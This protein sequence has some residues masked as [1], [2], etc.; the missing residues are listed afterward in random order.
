[1]VWFFSSSYATRGKECSRKGTQ[2]IADAGANVSPPV[3]TQL[4]QLSALY[5]RFNQ[6][7]EIDL[8]PLIAALGVPEFEPATPAPNPHRWRAHMLWQKAQLDRV[9]D[10][11]LIQAVEK[12]FEP[13]QL[14]LGKKVLDGLHGPYYRISGTVDGKKIPESTLVSFVPEG[15]LTPN[16]FSEYQEALEFLSKKGL[17]PQFRGRLSNSQYP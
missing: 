16:T 1:M 14:T 4:Y 17:G 5:Q 2:E 12:A 15:V 8:K 11:L 9:Y 7:E 10:H 13:K 6:E 3:S